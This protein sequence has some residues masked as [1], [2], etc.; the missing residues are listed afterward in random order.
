MHPDVNIYHCGCCRRERASAAVCNMRAVEA[1]SRVRTQYDVIPQC[2]RV[3]TGSL[4]SIN[5]SGR[6]NPQTSAF[7]PYYSDANHEHCG[8]DGSRVGMR[9][10]IFCIAPVISY[11]QSFQIQIE[12]LWAARVAYSLDIWIVA[13]MR[14]SPFDF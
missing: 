8:S 12:A 13:D 2:T 3:P 1:V 14:H 10:V 4:V 6:H 9:F 5:H 11:S 7:D